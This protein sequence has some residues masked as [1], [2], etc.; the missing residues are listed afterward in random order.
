MSPLAHSIKHYVCVCMRK[1]FRILR[2]ILFTDVS[3]SHHFHLD[4]LQFPPEE[5]KKIVAFHLMSYAT[6]CFP[7]FHLT[8]SIGS[9]ITI[10]ERQA[11]AEWQVL[12]YNL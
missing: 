2:R 10:L 7:F 11:L 1:Y 9:I 4:T 6:N 12:E 3:I 5:G 8:K